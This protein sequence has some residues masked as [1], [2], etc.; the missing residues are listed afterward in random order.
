MTRSERKLML[1]GAAL[2]G[3]GG[4]LCAASLFVA[5]RLG[6]GQAVTFQPVLV[7]PLAGAGAWLA[8]LVVYRFFGHPG[9]RGWVWAGL[10]YVL[11]T[12]LGAAV[13]GTGL[14]PGVGT[15]TA[16]LILAVVI[17]TSPVNLPVWLA[18]SAIIHLAMRKMRVA[19]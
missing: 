6:V 8:G 12:G 7:V 3:I 13:A 18:S 10:G 16:P 9:R 17:A 5:A 11:A 1:I 4:G 19:P 2:I 15:L 14:Y